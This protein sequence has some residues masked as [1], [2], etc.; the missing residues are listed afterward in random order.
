MILKQTQFQ[1]T[2]PF[3]I[4]LAIKK[5]VIKNG[6][7]I[8][9]VHEKAK[10]HPYVKTTF[11]KENPGSQKLLEHLPFQKEYTNIIHSKNIFSE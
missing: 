8:I 4:H 11:T 7:S 10:I 1:S 6:T 3:Q 2:M 9:S 5:V